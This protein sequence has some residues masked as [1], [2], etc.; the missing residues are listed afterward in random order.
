MPR[1]VIGCRI[2]RNRL[3][4]FR[5]SEVY[6]MK[7]NF[8]CI[9]CPN[10]CEIETEFEEKDGKLVVTKVTGNTCKRGDEYVRQ[11]LTDPRRT[12]TS[13]V[14]VLG[15][16]LPLASVRLTGPI[17]KNRIFDA[18]KEIKKIAVKAPVSAGT[19][20][21]HNLFGYDSDVVVTKSVAAVR[22]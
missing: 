15:G 12:I 5:L 3:R 11:E 14:L 13:S 6:S 10:S 20:L 18:M 17:P 21:I 22:R 2:R 4:G 9:I 1:G 8:T 19:V 7:K 16:E